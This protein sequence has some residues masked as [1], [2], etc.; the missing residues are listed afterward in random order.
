MTTNNITIPSDAVIIEN[1]KATTTSLK[2]AEIFGKEHKHVM[3]DIRNLIDFALNPAK[4][5]MS[6]F[7]QAPDFMLLNFEE[8][9]FIHPQNNQKYPCYNLTKDGFALLV[10]GYTGKKAI[11]F[12]I[13]YIN[14][15]N[16]M[17]KQLDTRTIAE[18]SWDN[19]EIWKDRFLKLMQERIDANRAHET[20]IQQVEAYLPTIPFTSGAGDKQFTN[21]LKTQVRQFDSE[22]IVNALDICIRDNSKMRQELV[23]TNAKIAKLSKET[24]LSVE[25]SRTK[26]TGTP[27]AFGFTESK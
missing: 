21:M 16:E 9:N 27:D 5:G 8:T 22:S 18:P 17:Q 3:R 13:A 23:D 15:F 7:G 11:N 4:K 20:T 6:K 1:G 25:I 2:V 12:K 19:S 24:K 10:M 26:I 14:K